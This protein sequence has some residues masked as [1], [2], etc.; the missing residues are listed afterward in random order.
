MGGAIRMIR[1]VKGGEELCLALGITPTTVPRQERTE[2]ERNFTDGYDTSMDGPLLDFVDEVYGAHLWN[3]SIAGTIGCA[4]G[5]VTANS[6]SLELLVQGKGG[7]ASSPQGTVDAVVVAAQL[8]TALQGIVSRNV[9]PTE[10]AVITLGQIQGGVAPNVIAES[11]RIMGTVRTYTRP[12]KQLLRRRIHEVA[13]GIA[14][15]HGPACTI[16]VKFM[17]GYPACVNN[18]TCA[19]AVLTA[20]REMLGEQLGTRLVGPPTPNMAGEDFSFFLARK[21]GAF[22]FVGS[23]PDAAF[24]LDPAL[25]PEPTDQEHGAKRVIFHHTPEFDIHEGALWC[26]AAMWVSLAMERLCGDD[27]KP[28]S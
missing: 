1:D 2:S 25:P 12:V 13:T 16:Q 14:S 28:V 18:E 3:Y 22:F 6:D 23:N 24:G 5:S 8:V 21:P 20:G 19:A 27:G 26:G 10:S 7:H 9:S 11:A 17:D 4:G 15:S